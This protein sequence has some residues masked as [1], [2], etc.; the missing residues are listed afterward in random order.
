[1]VR[2]FGVGKQVGTFDVVFK[3]FPDQVVI[4]PPPFVV[5]SSVGPI[6]PPAV[7][8][9]LGI[10]MAKGINKSIVHKCV[11]PL[12]FFGQKA[13]NI[14]IA[15]RI[16]DVDGSVAN[17]IIT[18]DHQSGMI[19]FQ[20]I[21]ILL[22]IVHEF[23]LVFQSVEIGTGGEVEADDRYI[24]I[25]GTYDPAFKIPTEKLEK[26]KKYRKG[27]ILFLHDSKKIKKLNFSTTGRD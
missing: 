5:V 19:F 16:V 12:A 11:N 18:T 26:V 9:R 4:D 27:Q 21:N 22:K 17:V 3:V 13:G 10:E 23:E 8:V 25:I 24:L 20:G 2:M 7:L 14:F 6:A 1:M 15:N